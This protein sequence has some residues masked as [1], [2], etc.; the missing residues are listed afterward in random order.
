[1]PEKE[2][3]FLPSDHL[4]QPD[5]IFSIAKTFVQLGVHKI[6]LTGGEPLV[7]QDAATIIKQLSVLPVKLSL[8][9]NGVFVHKFIP[10]FLDAGIQSVNVSLDSL[11]PEKF[12]IITRRNQFNNVW[13]NIQ[14]LL[15]NNF[16]VKLNVVVMKG[17]NDNEIN[18]FVALT[19]DLPFHIR[20]IEFMPFTGNH[21]IGKNVVTWQQ[22]LSTIEKE[23]NYI[24]LKDEANDTTKKYMVPGHAGTFAVI[25]TLSSPF[26]SSCNRMRLTADGKM[27]NC[28]FSANETDLLSAF[29]KGEDI[30]PLIH[31]NIHVKEKE[32]GGQF[33]PDFENIQSQNIKNRSMIAIGG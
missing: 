21:W 26:C 19:K 11:E 25:S 18:S 27:K 3:A 17:I 32:R 7:R 31:Q 8:T 20:F 33:L 13:K 10:T 28:L 9:T 16:H 2:Y 30:I 24:K 12:A 23:Y 1:M 6:R 4:M 5:E 22:I 15:Q 29:R 14:S